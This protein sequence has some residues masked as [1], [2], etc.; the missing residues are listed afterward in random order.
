[1][2]SFLIRCYP[3]R[4]QARYGDEFEA[5]LEE[6]PLGP[7]DVADILLGAL[8]AHLRFAGR[9]ATDHT[10]RGFAMSLRIGG[11]AAI[12]GVSFLALGLLS[13]SGLFA[14]VDSPIPSL[15]MIIGAVTL[16]VA[17]AGLSAF[18][19]RAHPVLTWSAFAISTIATLVCIAGI[20]G[21]SIVESGTPSLWGSD[22]AP[23]INVGGLLGFVGF[24]LFG[25]ATYRTAAFSRRAALL[26]AVGSFLTPIA[27]FG[28]TWV[29]A[30]SLLCILIGWLALGLQAIRLD[31]RAPDP[32]PA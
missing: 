5:I 16:L 11:I 29:L 26:L 1:M 4:W 18:Q 10:G 17:I 7:F 6:R 27:L 25:I 20:F 12:I 23:L 9:G 31:Q 21:M 3:A 30:A 2:R 32:R 28:G 8:D 14:T 13:S 22:W 24:G 19:A 15:L